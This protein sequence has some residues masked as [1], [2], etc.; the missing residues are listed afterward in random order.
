MGYISQPSGQ[1]Q[2]LI[3]GKAALEF[4]VTLQSQ[5]WQSNDGRVRMNYTVIES[6]D[7]DS[8]GL[9]EIDAAGAWLEAGKPARFEVVGSAAGSQRWF[10]V[11]L[12][13]GAGQ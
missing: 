9:L 2:L 5:S 11:Y 10:G 13:P 4:D 12:L 3:N 7:E 1:F 6:N 8:N